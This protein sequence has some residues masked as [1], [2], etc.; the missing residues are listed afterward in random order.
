MS[1]FLTGKAYYCFNVLLLVLVHYHI[2]SL[3]AWNRYWK[4]KGYR[5]VVYLDYG[6][7]MHQITNHVLMS[8][9]VKLDLTLAGIIIQKKSIWELQNYI[10]CFFFIWDTSRGTLTIPSHKVNK[11]LDKIIYIVIKFV[12]VTP[13]V[14]ARIAGTTCITV[15][16]REV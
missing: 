13:L 11:L 8:N 3:T 7:G 5:I 12:T 15:S 14:L 2:Y 1:R 16:F 4:E 10:E 6:V 9:T